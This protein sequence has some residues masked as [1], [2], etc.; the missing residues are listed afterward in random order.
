MKPIHQ[1]LAALVVLIGT[2]VSAA[3]ARPGHGP[4]PGHGGPGGGGMHIQSAT[5]G[6]NCGVR[7]DNATRSVRQECNG[8]TSCSYLVSVNKIG[9]PAYGCAKDFRVQYMCPNGERK[10][11]F[12]SPEANNR[13]AEMRCREEWNR[14][15]IRVLVATYGGN[16]PEI[17]KG[18]VTHDIAR[19]CNGRQRCDYFISVNKIGDP[20][21]GWSKDYYVEYTC[22]GRD[23]R[24]A[25]VR[26]EANTSTVTL[27]CN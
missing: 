23:R 24:S 13:V 1:M 19:E 12:V 17:P 16:F 21:Y 8:S 15:Q 25:Y 20:K 27:V 4:G 22:D 2:S 14:R 9:D 26:P 3:N 5:Y 6:A 11:A 18:N 10:Q 7:N